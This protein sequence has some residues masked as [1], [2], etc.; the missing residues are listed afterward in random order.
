M[1][2]VGPYYIIN[3][4]GYD[5]LML[6]YCDTRLWLRPTKSTDMGAHNPSSGGCPTSQVV[7]KYILK[8]HF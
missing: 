2:I 3:V 6:I 4:C 1:A 7:Y 5:Q 8:S